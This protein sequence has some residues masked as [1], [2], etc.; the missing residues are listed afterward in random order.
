[1]KTSNKIIVFDLIRGSAALLVCASHLRNALFLD[2]HQV[3]KPNLIQKVFYL[4]TGV[5]HESVMVFFVLSGFFVGGSVLSQGKVFNWMQYLIARITRLWVVLLPALLFTFVV[6]LVVQRNFPE[7]VSGRYYDIFHSVPK[8]LTDYSTSWS[9]FFCNVTFLQTIISPVYGVNG[10]LWS[11]SNEFWYYILFPLICCVL[12][13]SGEYSKLNRLAFLLLCISILFYLPSTIIKYFLVWLLG[14]FLWYLVNICNYKPSK[15][16]I[17][18]LL[19]IF[20]YILSAAKSKLIHDA[21][22]SDII[23]GA[24]F[25]LLALSAIQIKNSEI[26]SVVIRV[27]EFLSNTSFTL[28]LFHFP[29]IILYITIIGINKLVPTFANITY[30]LL[31][32]LFIV[33]ICYVFYLLAEKRTSRIRNLIQ[34]SFSRGTARSAS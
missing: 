33:F 34:N 2:Y 7:L 8:A 16:F 29:I 30:Y 3:D 18:I 13:F 9:T 6:D 25:S 11:L 24:S 10:P 17:I 14:V 15:Y 19:P 20:I 1:M 31:I 12:G 27:S 21:F 22:L 4:L 5:G 26:N 32:L 28:Y 23:V